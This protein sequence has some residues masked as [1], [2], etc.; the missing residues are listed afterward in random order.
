MVY[1]TAADVITLNGRIVGLGGDTVDVDPTVEVLA[2]EGLGGDD[3]FEI[4]ASN[5]PRIELF[6][7]AGDD[8]YNIADVSSLSSEIAIFDSV[9]SENDTLLVTGTVNSDEFVVNENLITVNGAVLSPTNG[10]NIIGVEGFTF[11][12]RESDDIFRICLLY[13]SDAADE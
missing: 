10:G 1:T 5:N 9:G 11:D 6:G 8:L 3:R 13:T 7:Q 2:L 12:G 4:F